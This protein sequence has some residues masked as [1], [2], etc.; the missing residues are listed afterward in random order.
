[1]SDEPFFAYGYLSD[2]TKGDHSAAPA[3]FDA[4][5]ALVR[6]AISDLRTSG[7]A[8]EHAA[9]AIAY[10][11]RTLEACQGAWLLLE[12]GMESSAA[13]LLRTAYECLFHSLALLNKPEASR[14]MEAEHHKQRLKTASEARKWGA[15]QRP[16]DHLERLDRITSAEEEQAEGGYTAFDA[17]KDAGLLLEYQ[18]RW[19][20]LG[21]IGAHATAR[22]LD[23][24]VTPQPDGTWMFELGPGHARVPYLMA[25]TRECLTLG[26]P[27]IRAVLHESE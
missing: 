19:R 21:M 17:A 25:L 10:W 26:L 5:R 20:I 18:E 8:P 27:K 11:L 2:D 6:E 7:A 24:V 9:I 15:D 3:E 23:S 16:A 1:M 22:S 14:A 12:R 4:V 13:A